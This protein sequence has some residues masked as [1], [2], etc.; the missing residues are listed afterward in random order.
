MGGF[1]TDVDTGNPVLDVET[2]LLIPVDDE[3]AI[4]Q[5]IFMLLNC[6]PGSEILHPYYG[7]DLE[8][9][10]RLSNMDES[11]MFIESLLADALDPKKEKLISNVNYIKATKDEDDPRKI[12]VTFN[13][14][15][16]S[17]QNITILEVIGE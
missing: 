13:L 6:E 10:L 15:T 16:I 8:S 2:G 12:N 7:F 17:G 3:T 5:I 11:E 9:A 1:L 14:D 4:R